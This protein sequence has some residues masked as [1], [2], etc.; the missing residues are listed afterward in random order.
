MRKAISI[1]LIVLVVL[2]VLGAA[3]AIIVPLATRAPLAYGARPLM[4][5]YLLGGFGLAG[6][7][8]TFLFLLLIV[9]AVV[10]LADSGERGAARGAL[11][12]SPETPLEI[13]KRRYAQGE[14]TKEQYEDMKRELGA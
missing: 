6:S 14:I 11:P 1:L 7:L 2:L 9:L 4:H 8:V 5:P 12:T 3:A 10:S 13:L